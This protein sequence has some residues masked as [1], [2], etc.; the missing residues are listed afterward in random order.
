[1]TD[2]YFEAPTLGVRGCECCGLVVSVPPGERRLRCPR[3]RK[4]LHL[5]NPKSLERTAALLLTAVVLYIPANL[6][7]VMAT[8]SVLGRDTHTLVGGILD[9]WT[10]GSWELSL[11]VFIASIAV[12]LLKIAALGLLAWTAQ[13]RSRW[14]Q[15][16]R[17][18]LYRLVETVGHWSMLDVFVVVLLVGMV[19]FGVLASVEVEPGLLAFGAVV[20]ATMLA[21]ACF[22]PRL[23]W[24]LPDEAE[25]IGRLQRKIA[26]LREHA[27]RKRGALERA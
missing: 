7:P 9:L 19:H 23:I 13:K 18:G 8:S 1:M 24:P 17:A 10:S 16:E 14:R 11:I 26:A 6:L 21:S 4:T 27:H 5:H 20:V 15:R 22:D 2:V 12:P 25:R 3:C